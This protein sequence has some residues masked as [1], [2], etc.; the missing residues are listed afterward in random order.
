MAGRNRAASIEVNG[1][2]R[3]H[4]Q[5]LRRLIPGLRV[6]Y[7]ARNGRKV[8][9]SIFHKARARTSQRVLDIVV[10]KSRN[11]FHQACLYWAKTS[12]M[13]RA[14]SDETWRFEDILADYDKF[15]ALTKKL[16][17]NVSERTWRAFREKRINVG[18]RDAPP[19]TLADCRIFNSVCATENATLGYEA[20]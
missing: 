20:S 1:L 19:W 7:L 10:P 9:N 4:I 6:F 8:V 18:R 12:Q 3:Y 13:L 16:G 15:S 14:V 17:A 2:I 5:S 11:G